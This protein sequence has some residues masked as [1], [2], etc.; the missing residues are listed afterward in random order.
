MF[1]DIKN[2]SRDGDSQFGETKS[3]S[4]VKT[5][6]WKVN[7]QKAQKNGPHSTIYW[8]KQ[9]KKFED[10]TFK[11]EKWRTSS[12]YT[13][14]WNN[15][16]KSGFGIQVFENGDKYEGSWEHNLMNGQGTLWVLDEKKNLRRRYTGDWVNDKKEGRGTMFFNNEDRYDG[17]WKDNLQFGEGR[18][19]YKNGDV[20]VGHWDN[21]KRSGYGVLTKRNGD[22]FEGNWV[23]DMREGQGSYFFALKNKLFVGE[24]VE[25][26]PKC[27]IY[28]EVSD[29]AEAKKGPDYLR[30]FDDIPPLPELQLRDPIQVLQASLSKTRGKRIFYRANYMSLHIMFEHDEITKMIEEFKYFGETTIRDQD[31]ITL[32]EKIDIEIDIQTL[33]ELIKKVSPEDQSFDNID[34]EV[35]ARTVALILD[36]NNRLHEQDERS[37]DLEKSFYDV[38]RSQGDE[39][40]STKN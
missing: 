14:S 40:K 22:H 38:I 12:K 30:D 15:N 23:N 16:M 1:Q 2:T 27:G 39:V 24:Y 21:G 7:D 33:R 3:K 36:E 5:Q 6:L 11:G 19:I 13:G 9:Q 4:R 29:P 37:E 26:L 18:M 10:G 32:L 28:T 20:Y 31:M 35:F 17:F 34:F 8:V 25:D